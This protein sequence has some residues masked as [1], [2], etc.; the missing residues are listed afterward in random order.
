MLGLGLVLFLG[1]RVKY[2]VKFIV[3]VNIGN[4]VG[5]RVRARS[6]T[7]DWFG[8]VLRLNL[9]WICGWVSV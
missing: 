4:G 8:L 2:C 6:T 3:S 5:A 7:W 1:V 9:G